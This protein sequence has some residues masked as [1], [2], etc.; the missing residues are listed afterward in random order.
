MTP[1]NYE[2]M[3]E[4]PNNAF[5]KLDDM[6]DQ[7]DSGCDIATAFW[8]TFANTNDPR[9][10]DKTQA[11]RELRRFKNYYKTLDLHQVSSTGILGACALLQ[12]SQDQ[13]VGHLFTNLDDPCAVAN[14]IDAMR[15]EHV[16]QHIYAIT[17]IDENSTFTAHNAD[18][19]HNA[20]NQLRNKYDNQNAN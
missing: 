16:L 11:L 17:G 14:T 9:H 20:I 19:M 18:L 7:F 1:T 2:P 15:A 13:Q 3:I 12:K 10:Y 8:Q 4:N 5:D 6:I